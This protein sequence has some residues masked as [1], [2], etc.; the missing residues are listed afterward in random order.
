M[1]EDHALKLLFANDVE[2]EFVA[3]SAEARGEVCGEI[4]HAAFDV[5]TDREG[6][7]ER[8]RD[9]AHECGILRACAFAGF[10]IEVDDVKF[11]IIARAKQVD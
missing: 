7:S 11:E 10:V 8:R 6:A 4:G 1:G 9:V 2:E 3:H 5:G